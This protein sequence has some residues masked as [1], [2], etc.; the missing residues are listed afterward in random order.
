MSGF[1]ALQKVKDD[2]MRPM[3]EKRRHLGCE[4]CGDTF[5]GHYQK[6][7]YQSDKVPTHDDVFYPD[8]PT[9]GIAFT[10]RSADDAVAI[11]KHEQE[12]KRKNKVAAEKR[13]ATRERKIKEYWN[14]VRHVRANPHD[15]TTEELHS[16]NFVQALLCMPYYSGYDKREKPCWE[17]GLNGQYEVKFNYVDQG[18]SRS[19]KTH[20]TRQWFDITNTNTGEVW[21]AKR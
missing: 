8:C 19:G 15:A 9:C 13:K 16:F 21:E 1:E 18:T 10:V 2:M 11:Y 20:Y 7:G 17:Q 3:Y 6:T 14:R 12:K 5:Y 4:L